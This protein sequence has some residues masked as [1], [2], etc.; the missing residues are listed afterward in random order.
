VDGNTV[1]AKTEDGAREYTVPDDF[2]FSMGGK[3]ISVRELAPGMKGTATITTTTATRPVF[4]T[5]VRE[6]EVVQASASSVIV[7]GKNGFQ[8]F[9]EGDVEKRGI[10]IFKDGK[11]V[12]FSDL[13]TRDRLTATIVTEGTPQTVTEREVQAR[14]A[15]PAPAA[16]KGLTGGAP[17]PPPVASAPPTSS[18]ASAATPAPAP[19]PAASSPAPSTPPLGTVATQTPGTETTTSP[20]LIGTVLGAIALAV[21]WLLVRRRRRA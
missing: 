15:E 4:V 17:T 19:A 6:A 1:V 16:A 20:L 3:Q 2:R 7:R 21:V 18:P 5:E 13:R 11:P 10:R 9:T 14:L 8:M 12:K